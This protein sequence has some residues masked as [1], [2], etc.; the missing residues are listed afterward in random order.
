M[1]FCEMVK[2]DD[3]AQQYIP[4]TPSTGEVGRGLPGHSQVSCTEID[5]MQKTRG[6]G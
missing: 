4:G 5:G 1:T 2:G 3:T 6:Q